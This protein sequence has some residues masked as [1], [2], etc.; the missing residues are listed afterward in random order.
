MLTLLRL[1][2]DGSF[3]SGSELGSVLGVSRS[4]VWKQLQRIECESGVVVNKVRG[5]GYQL[6]E[7]ISLLDTEKI[8]LPEGWSLEL[9]EVLDST[10][11]EAMRQVVEGRQLPLVVL[12]ERQTSGRG[13]RGRKWESPLAENL[14][15]SL[16]LRIESG[17]RQLEGLSLVIGL[18]VLNTLRVSGL[19]GGALK[20]PNDIL[21]QGKK[22][23]G[24]LLELTGDPADICHVIIGVGIN[25]N[26]ISAQDIDQAWTSM[27]LDLHRSVDRNELTNELCRQLSLYIRRH[28]DHGFSFFRD[29]WEASN[30]WQGLDAMLISGSDRIRGRVLGVDLQ[31]RLRMSING[32]EQVFGAGELSLRAYDDR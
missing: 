7:P 5:R 13:R 29:E 1:L 16:A 24:V 17:M 11:A 27:R 19:T 12:A 22:I 14:Y 18:A 15:C 25:V 26:M 23:A 31:G 10:N 9:K 8:E 2:Q 4:A 6:V 21:F 3:H 28:V 20:W 32:Q 30:I